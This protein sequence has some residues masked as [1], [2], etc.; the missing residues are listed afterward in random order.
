MPPTRRRHGCSRSCRQIV[1]RPGPSTACPSPRSRSPRWPSTRNA[2]P[3]LMGRPE[4]GA[5]P[6]VAQSPEQ[7]MVSRGQPGSKSGIRSPLVCCA[8][9]TRAG[10]PILE[11]SG[12][13]MVISS[14][15]TGGAAELGPRSTRGAFPGRR[16]PATFSIGAT[17]ATSL[18]DS[19]VVKP[20]GSHTPW[21]RQL[22]D[23]GERGRRCLPMRDRRS[24]IRCVVKASIAVKFEAQPVDSGPRLA[25]SSV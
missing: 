7:P 1:E 3:T 22:G 4:V 17:G 13:K 20:T 23:G 14:P 18:R 11:P 12:R 2:A 19:G 8:G 24:R 16:R 25:R 6:R 9:K 15:A 21:L 5:L 10:E